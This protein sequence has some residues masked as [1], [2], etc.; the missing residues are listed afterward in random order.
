MSA[1]QALNG[2]IIKSATVKDCLVNLN[3][4]GCDNKLTLAWVKAHA[5]V[6]GNERADILAKEGASG[7]A[8]QIIELVPPQSCQKLAI[9]NY[10]YESWT[11]E[12]SNSAIARTTKLFFPTPNSEKALRLIDKT[13][14]EISILIMFMSGH[15]F[16][17]KHRFIQKQIQSNICRLCDAGEESV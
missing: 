1:L 2:L 6:F 15:S 13:R 11:R 3:R 16:L 10:F 9:R 5:N 8:G 17:R 7:S 12:F 14:E 4:L